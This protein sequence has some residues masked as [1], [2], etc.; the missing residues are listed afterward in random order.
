MYNTHVSCESVVARKGLLLTAMRALH[1][2]LAIVVDGILVSRQV[3]GPREDG[4]ARL[5]R[6]WVNA[7]AL[8]RTGL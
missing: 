2:L 4:V 6:G 7:A 8:V 3:V 5:A 1:L